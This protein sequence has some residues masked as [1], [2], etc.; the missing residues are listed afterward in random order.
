MLHYTALSWIRICDVIYFSAALVIVSLRCLASPAGFFETAEKVRAR[1]NSTSSSKKLPAL[2]NVIVLW[3]QYI[4][5]GIHSSHTGTH[6][7]THKHI[8]AHLGYVV[9]TELLLARHFL[10][11]L[12]LLTLLVDIITKEETELVRLSI[13]PKVTQG[14]DSHTSRPASKSC[15][16]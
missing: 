15:A 13:V 11:L 16:F 14:Q 5:R 1:S 9:C 8:C 3:P 6:I 4:C 7:C 10:L 12:L 2:R